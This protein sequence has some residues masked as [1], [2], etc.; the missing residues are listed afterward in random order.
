MGGS[1]SV[2][3]K[4]SQNQ[5]ENADVT[6]DFSK[7]ASSEAF[8]SKITNLKITKSSAENDLYSPHTRVLFFFKCLSY[9]MESKNTKSSI[10][11]TI[12]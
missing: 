4:Y 9:V 7:M 10:C 5:W 3:N 1:G 11:R 8:I 2:S 6:V 12:L